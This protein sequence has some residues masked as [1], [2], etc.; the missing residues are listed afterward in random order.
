MPGSR[1]RR[2]P[3]R[4]GA[5]RR[6]EFI[7]F[8]LFWQGTLNRGD[9]REQFGISQQQASADIAAYQKHAPRNTEYDRN[10]KTYVRAE[11]FESVFGGNWFT[12][13]D[14]LVSNWM[15]PLGGFGVALFVG[16]RMDEAIRHDHFLSGSSFAIFYRG[17]LFLLRYV[18]PVAI[19]LVFLHAVGVI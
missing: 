5:Q 13:V 2:T 8:R 18:V 4:W 19:V 10:A 12:I 16:W 6:L 17:W 11:G 7:E 3:P 15:V 14:Y 1:S 9:L